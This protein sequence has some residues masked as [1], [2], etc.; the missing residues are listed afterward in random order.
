[1]NCFHTRFYQLSTLFFLLFSFLNAAGPALEPN[2][3]ARIDF[4][5]QFGIHSP[6]AAEDDELDTADILLPDNKIMVKFRSRFEE[7]GVFSIRYDLREYTLSENS[8][9]RYYEPYIYKFDHRLKVGAGYT[10]NRI[11]TPYAFYEYYLPMEGSSNRSFIFGSRIVFSNITMLEPSYSLTL[12]EDNFGQSLILR[13]HQ[14]L[15]P[16]FFIMIKNILS[17]ISA[18]NS[19]ANSN[20]LDIYS[21]YRVHLKTAIH[22][23]YRYYTDFKTA[24]SYIAWCQLRQQLSKN[25]SGFVRFRGLLKYPNEFDSLKYN[26]FSTEL[27]MTRK[28]FSNK[29]NGRN[30]VV[31]L[32]GIFFWNNRMIQS[33]TIGFE[34]NYLFPK[35]EQKE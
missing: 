6:P 10:L 8:Y 32:Y 3:N 25:Y 27:R 33:N 7:K 11:F 5:Y 16:R 28:P 13:L 19:F 23:G 2:L 18:N 22:F 17:Q 24:K 21:G 15:T 35:R 29:G 20:V 4:A 34:I 9:R 26:S 1:M 31:T 12:S 14:V 30:L